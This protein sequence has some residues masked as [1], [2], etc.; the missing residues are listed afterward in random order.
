M[1]LNNNEE[2][3]IAF[4]LEKVWCRLGTNPKKDSKR[5]GV[6]TERTNGEYLIWKSFNSRRI[7]LDVHLFH[8]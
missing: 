3:V 8:S 7:K 2:G 1:V 4:K 6:Y 5:I